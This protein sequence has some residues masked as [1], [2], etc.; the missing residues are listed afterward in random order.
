MRQNE[1][2]IYKKNNNNNLR[3]KNLTWI[4]NEEDERVYCFNAKN[5]FEKVK[6]TKEVLTPEYDMPEQHKGIM[7]NFTNH[8]LYGEELIASG[9]EGVNGLL[10]CNSIMLSSWKNTTVEVGADGNEDE[11]YELLKEKIKTSRRKETVASDGAVADLSN[12][13]NN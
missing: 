6:H 10:L 2:K 4:K 13:Y 9:Y 12:T 8:L 5:G 1:K 7:Q 11:F 3:E